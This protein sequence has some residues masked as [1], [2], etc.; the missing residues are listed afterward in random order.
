[1]VHYSPDFIVYDA[2][3]TKCIY[4][5][6]ISVPVRVIILDPLS[7]KVCLICDTYYSYDSLLLQST[8][9]SLILILPE[10]VKSVYMEIVD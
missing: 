5:T 9:Q 4:V 3:T 1:M 6:V 7:I 8:N 2:S 10:T